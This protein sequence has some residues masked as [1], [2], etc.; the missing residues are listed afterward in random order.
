MLVKLIQR[1]DWEVHKRLCEK[2]TLVK[3]NGFDHFSFD[4]MFHCTAQCLREKSCLNQNKWLYSYSFISRT[5]TWYFNNFLYKL[6]ILGLIL[7]PGTL[8]KWWLCPCNARLCWFERRW[9]CLLSS[10][11]PKHIIT[12]Y[13]YRGQY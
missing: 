6:S 12:S 13:Y 10:S 7:W 9:D 8:I 3:L 2:F 5:M 4:L 1:V 11:K